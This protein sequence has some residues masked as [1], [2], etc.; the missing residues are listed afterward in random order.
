[1]CPDGN[2]LEINN[3]NKFSKENNLNLS[4][5]FLTHK[6]KDYDGFARNHHKGYKIVSKL[7]L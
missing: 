5:I 1:L 4:S 3:L 7:K 2:I 6:G